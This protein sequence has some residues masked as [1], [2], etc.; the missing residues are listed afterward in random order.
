MGRISIGRRQTAQRD[1]ESYFAA[2]DLLDIIGLLLDPGWETSEF[3]ARVN[4]IPREDGT[5]E[6]AV[7]Q[8]DPA[9]AA[10]VLEWLRGC[11]CLLELS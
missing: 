2:T 7:R 10:V 11:V 5:T 4:I 1:W 3:D 8:D 9:R 6:G